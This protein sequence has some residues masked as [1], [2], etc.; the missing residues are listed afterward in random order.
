ML[1]TTCFR[2]KTLPCPQAETDPFYGANW[3]STVQFTYLFI[4]IIKQVIE[5]SVYHLNTHIFEFRRNGTKIMQQPPKLRIRY[6]WNYNTGR[7][8]D[9]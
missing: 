2:N 4:Y 5:Q 1:E 6:C 8:A 3:P 7:T 9:L